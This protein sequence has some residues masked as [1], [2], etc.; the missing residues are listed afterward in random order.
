[1]AE[2]GSTSFTPGDGALA[3][4]W[5]NVVGGR[6][7]M[8]LEL[9]SSLGGRF[10]CSLLSEEVFL[11]VVAG[12]LQV[13]VDVGT[14]GSWLQV[15]ASA[16]SLPWRCADCASCSWLSSFWQSWVRSS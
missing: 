11:I 1:M 14:V 6:G 16:S 7:A 9:I 3:L 4:L 2:S 13:S 8:L 10:P 15:S 12:M 5:P